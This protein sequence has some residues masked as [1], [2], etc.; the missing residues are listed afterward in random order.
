M[1]GV[2]SHKVTI[3]GADVEISWTNEVQR[4]FRDRV[5][6]IGADY[7]K[8]FQNFR[9]PRKSRYAYFAWL[10]FF[11]PMDV[12]RKFEIPEDLMLAVE[13]KDAQSVVSAVLG[14]I[15]EMSPSAEKKSTSK[16]SPSP[17]SNSG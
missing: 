9:N 6:K 2:M 5:S 3:G 10:W 16:K 12:Y 13:D 4:G 14:T 1:G 8:L 11:L 15:K 7:E 17:G